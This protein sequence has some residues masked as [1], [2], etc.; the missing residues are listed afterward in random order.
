MT[1]RTIGKYELLEEIGR[2]GFAVV[3]RARDTSLDRVVALKVL[4]PHWVTDPQFATRFRQEARAAANLRHPNIVTVH[5]TGEADGQ[6]Y[7]AMAYLPGHTLQDLLEEQG[8]LSLEAALPILDQLA[9]ALDYAHGQGVIHRDVKPLNVMVEDTTRGLRATLMDFGLVKALESSTALTSQGTLLGSPEYMAPEQADPNRHAEIGSATDRYAL[10]IVAYRMLAGRVPFPGN[11]PGTLN[12]H[13]NLKVPDPRDFVQ[14]VPPEVTAALLAM[15]V[16]APA[17]RFPTASVFVARLREAQD[18]ERQR[19]ASEVHLA[20]QYRM[21]QAAIQQEAWEDAIQL[22]QRIQQT[23]LDYA[24][25]ARLVNLA[26]QKHRDAEAARA[27]TQVREQQEVRLVPLHAQLQVAVDRQDWP[28]VLHI[29][30]HIQALEPDDQ[31]AAQWIAYALEKVRRPARP[32]PAASPLR[33]QQVRQ[34]QPLP[35]WLKPAG[36]GLAAVIVLGVIGIFGPKLWKTVFATYTPTLKQTSAFPVPLCWRAG[37]TWTRPTDGMTMVCVPGDTFQMGSETGT[38]NEKPVHPVT[39]SAFWID[40]T[41]VTNAQ[42]AKCVTDKVC[43]A[44]AYANDARFNG[45]RQPVVG[46][47][48]NNAVAYCT[49]AGGQLPTEAQWEYAARGPEGYVYPWGNTFDCKYGNFDDETEV[50]SYVVPGGEGCDGYVRTAPVGSFP[51]GKSWVGAL[52]MAGNVWEWTAD[53]YA[54]NYPSE[55]QTDPQGPTEGQSKVVRGGSWYSHENLGR[56]SFRGRLA[57]TY[58]YNFVG[59]RCLVRAQGQ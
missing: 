30:G 1:L 21:L 4:H 48:W 17:D 56:A 22:G 13:L 35:A 11:T 39:L 6:L 2:G 5:D 52:D 14:D 41:E 9:D 8:A 38:D 34:R 54:N 32:Q 23:V 20:S 50:D 45:E 58:T 15:L 40:Q 18:A 46:V 51:E 29:G 12:A 24:D 43:T 28:E 44:S 47:D 16:K 42:Y 55:H 19:R 3:Y 36:I 59:F 27:A 26:Q 37:H 49:W 7:I 31:T 10:G 53:W 25:V 57:P 33:T